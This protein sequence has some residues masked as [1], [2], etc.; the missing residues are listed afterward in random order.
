MSWN[1]GLKSW[2]EV[3]LVIS[4]RSRDRL[5]L[6]SSA[7]IK[8]KL[9]TDNF[10]SSKM[11]GAVVEAHRPSQFITKKKLQIW[12]F[13]ICGSIMYIFSS[14]A[15]TESATFLVLPLLIFFYLVI[16]FFNLCKPNPSER[17]SLPLSVK[18][19]DC[20]LVRIQ[21]RTHKVYSLR[22]HYQ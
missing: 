9:P 20:V 17:N 8:T 11:I 22:Y 7:W 4:N 6:K 15:V 21:L 16:F 10:Y 5:I 12:W 18:R 13:L 19:P 2:S 14:S 1:H 3:I